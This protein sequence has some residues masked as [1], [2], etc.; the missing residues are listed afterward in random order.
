MC[1][2]QCSFHNR[3]Q[4]SFPARH[5]RHFKCV[6]HV[7]HSIYVIL[8]GFSPSYTG[9]QFDAFST[10]AARRQ[11][12]R[13]QGAGAPSAPNATGLPPVNYRRVVMP[14][15]LQRSIV[16][17]AEGRVKNKSANSGRRSQIFRQT[18]ANGRGGTKKGE[19]RPQISHETRRYLRGKMENCE[20]FFTAF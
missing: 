12:R 17:V 15:F 14:P 8:T 5:R 19:Y 2:S 16:A 20:N 1:Q 7:P 10:G 18:P 6:S 3:L 9:E 13:D 4:S 11:T